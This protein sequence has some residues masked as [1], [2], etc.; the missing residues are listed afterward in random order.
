MRRRDDTGYVTPA[1]GRSNQQGDSDQQASAV[2]L[3]FVWVAFYAA[4]SPAVQTRKSIDNDR[5]RLVKSVTA[6]RAIA[7]DVLMFSHESSRAIERAADTL[8]REITKRFASGL[9]MTSAPLIVER[10]RTDP[11]LRGFVRCAVHSC[12]AFFGSS[13]YST[14]ATLT[15][16]TF[17][18]HDM[19]AGRV[20]ALLRD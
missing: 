6:L 15:N 2:V 9:G 17:D 12:R 10:S 11:C 20:R 5:Q 13:L 14:V 18:R 16:V 19:T 1:W 8:D 3:L 7:N 4:A